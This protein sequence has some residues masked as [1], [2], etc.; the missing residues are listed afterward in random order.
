[1]ALGSPQ[2]PLENMVPWVIR[3]IEHTLHIQKLV[4]VHNSMHHPML[5]P[6]PTAL[7]WHAG[8]GEGGYNHHW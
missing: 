5:P 6:L 1:M 8:R 3:L 4:D 2:M 7:P